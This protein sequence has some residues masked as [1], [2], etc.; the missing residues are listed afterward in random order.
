MESITL[1]S[2][3]VLPFLKWG[4]AN[5]LGELKAL[6][7][8]RGWIPPDST[9]RADTIASLL[10]GRYDRQP[11]CHSNT[12]TVAVQTSIMAV[13]WRGN[14][15]YF[16][17]CFN[18]LWL[19]TDSFHVGPGNYS[20]FPVFCEPSR[21]PK[22]DAS[23]WFY[24]GL[25]SCLGI[26]ADVRPSSPCSTRMRRFFWRILFFFCFSF[27]IILVE[28][29]QQLFHSA[30]RLAG[31]ALPTKRSSF[32][33]CHIHANHSFDSIPTHNSASVMSGA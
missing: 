23:V 3:D 7:T 10:T 16:H 14:A 31:Y 27:I 11:Q 15:N 25:S 24:C 17:V 32:L 33:I 22:L 19:P 1:G 29:P 13:Q 21:A 12:F 2:G 9:D 8:R 18:W 30:M 20:P 28:Q 6:S 5:W 4:S 26:V